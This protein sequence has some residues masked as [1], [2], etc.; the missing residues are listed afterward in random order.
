MTYVGYLG[1]SVRFARTDF[2]ADGASLIIPKMFEAFDDKA[3]T[4]FISAMRGNTALRNRIRSPA[5]MSRL[6]SLG[7]IV[8]AK[9]STKF[10]DLDILTAL[11]DPAT[12]KKFIT[13]LDKRA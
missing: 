1:G 6:R 11:V 5:K 13:L 12:E 7:K 3:G 8:L 2:Y 4:A 9:V 10:P